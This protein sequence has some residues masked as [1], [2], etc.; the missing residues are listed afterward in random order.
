MNVREKSKRK[1][2]FLLVLP[3]IVV[4]F[5]TLIFWLLGGG[6]KDIFAKEP[7]EVGLRSELPDAK[8]TKEPVDKMDFYKIAEQDSIDK[9]RN[10]KS[11]PYLSAMTFAE[12]TSAITQQDIQGSNYLSY[13]GP[14]QAPV[15]DRINTLQKIIREQENTADKE[16]KKAASP[17][18]NNAE[19]DR[20]E[21]MMEMMQGGQTSTGS[22]MQQIN[23]AL[24]NIL[25]LQHP[26]RV[27]SKLKA[28]SEQHKTSAYPVTPSN[29]Q[30]PISSLDQGN[31]KLF[32]RLSNNGFFSLE[33]ALL[34]TSEQL[35]SIA[36]AVHEDQIV[37]SGST[38]KFRLLDDIYINGLLI[39]KDNFITG[40]ATLNG[41]RLQIEIKSIRNQQH[42]F[43]VAMTVYDLDG[44]PGINIPGAISRD[45]TKQ[46]GERAIQGLGLSTYDPSLGAQ[47][48]AA[49]ME[50][51]KNLLSKK[52]KLVR[53]QLKAGYQVLLYDEKQKNY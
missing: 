49:G 35:P 53:V 14:N 41:D 32:P 44:V 23:S 40:L 21:K 52:V 19:L 33:D 37:T 36:A 28:I 47:A 17:T 39:R 34:E 7:N 18:Q 31:E 43:P 8:I 15:Y 45:V 20:L 5:A 25:D 4:P 10:Q 3:V 12:E 16:Q 1:Q 6:S 11:D 27:R 48:A 29:Q 42:I 46:G 30:D 13:T 50:I 24:E 22:D 2:R 51:T 26:E 38:V 9:I